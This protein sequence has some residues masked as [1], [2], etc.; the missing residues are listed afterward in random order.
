MWVRGTMANWVCVYVQAL[1]D[2]GLVPGGDM[3]PEAALTKLSYVLAKEK[4]SMQEKRK[5]HT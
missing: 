1:S 4:L 2:A 5:V 3:T